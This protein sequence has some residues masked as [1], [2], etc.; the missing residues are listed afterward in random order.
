MTVVIYPPFINDMSN[1]PRKF[2]ATIG[3]A[4]RKNFST[5]IKKVE[6]LMKSEKGTPM[7]E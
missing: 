6:F 5:S 1:R 7:K 3:R 2:P 4:K